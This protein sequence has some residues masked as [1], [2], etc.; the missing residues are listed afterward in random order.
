MGSAPGQLSARKKLVFSMILCGFI[1]LV[2]ALSINLA[3]FLPLS[4]ANYHY[5]KTEGA[6]IKGKIFQYD[7]LL[8]IVPIPGSQGAYVYPGGY[9]V[10]VRFDQ[11]G[12][13]AP[14]DSPQ[15]SALKR[16][17]ILVLGDSY[18]FGF[19]VRAE[20]TYAYLLGRQL[21]ATSLNAARPGY[22][23]AQMTILARQLIPKFKPDLVVVQFS[24]WLVDRAKSPIS[25]WTVVR[26]ANPY[27][28]YE[29]GGGVSIQP[30]VFQTDFGQYTPAKYRYSPET[31][32]DYLSFLKET[33]WPLFLNNNIHIPIYHLK[34]WLRLIPPPV[35]QTE[36]ITEAAYGEMNE[37][38]RQNQARMMVVIMTD[39]V[40]SRKP[41]E[42]EITSLRSVSLA[43]IINTEPAFFKALPVQT[44]DAY[45][46]TYKI[47]SAD[48]KVCIDKHINA[49]AHR[50]ILSEIARGL[51]DF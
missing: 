3:A 25:D 40:I 43:T 26:L 31:M 48:G 17:I 20:D 21:K 18:S 1:F 30:P 33:G 6:I 13:R 15:S 41:T 37:L 32:R 12:F 24:P 42:A 39:P 35:S 28:A 50:L 45:S 44:R 22:G 16:P 27:F 34:K 10:P 29:R 23:L 46:R 8:G 5:F 51:N 14:M 9:E 7:P 36:K 47:Y 4:R 38:C 2:L 11:Y 19:G 49:S